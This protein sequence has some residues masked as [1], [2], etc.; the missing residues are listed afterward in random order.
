MLLQARP[1][2]IRYD[3]SLLL[4]LT[5]LYLLSGSLS[6]SSAIQA[7]VAVYGMILDLVVLVLFCYGCLMA[8]QLKARL[9]QTL[10]A[11]IGT[12]IIFHLMAWPVIEQLSASDR[13]IQDSTLALIFLLLMSWQVLVNA[14]IYRN[15]L[16]L[17]MTKAIVLAI[18]FWLMSMT[19]SQMI[20]PSPPPATG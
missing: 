13:L 9:V 20:F 15:A 4:V 11:L 18:A 5:V 14:H 19:L 12:G 8:L 16:M 17:D 7:D 6:L 10:S 1:Q 3:Q 2:D